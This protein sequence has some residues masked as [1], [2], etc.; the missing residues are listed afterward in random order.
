MVAIY[1]DN[2]ARSRSD[3]F[4]GI[5]GRGA[6][7]QAMTR[8]RNNTKCHFCGR[9]RHFKIK[10]PLRGQQEN[11]RQQ[12]QKREEKNKHPRR[13]HQRNRG[14]GRGPVWCS[15]HQTTSYSDADCRARRRK[16]A[17]G[18]AYIDAT[19][20]SRI[21]GICSA[22]DLPE[23]DDQPERAFISFT[24][25]ELH[26]TAALAAELDLP[27]EDDQPERPF[28]SFTATEVHSTAAIAAEQSHNEEMW[29][30]SSLSASRPWPFE[31]RA[32]PAISFG[33]QE[34]SDFSYMNGETD[35]DGGSFYGMA[36]VEPEPAEIECKPDE[37]GN[38][39]V[40]V[41]SRA[42]GHYFD[43]TII[44]D[45]KHHLQDYTSLR[46]LRRILTAGGA[47]LDGTAEGVL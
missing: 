19:G 12:S 39:T 33:V 46:A 1:A 17:D 22:F 11:D 35:G 5:A 20:S 13:Q 42:S 15:Y 38:V 34:K 30:F 40:L 24:A 9:V 37:S 47:L 44:P 18:S 29:P 10:C 7:M 32:K 43:D 3:S 45:L 28:I 41:D 16:Q 21:K 26:S 14:G 23:E 27:E 8:D 4:R 2:L 31:E 36:P 25:T 6:A